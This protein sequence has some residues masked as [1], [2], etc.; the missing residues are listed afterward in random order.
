[1][2]SC[3]VLYRKRGKAKPQIGVVPVYGNSGRKIIDYKFLPHSGV[4]NLVDNTLQNMGI[5]GVLQTNAETHYDIT[6]R[7][8]TTIFFVQCKNIVSS[9]KEIVWVPLSTLRLKASIN[10]DMLTR[11]NT[12]VNNPTSYLG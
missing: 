4:A 10:S 5:K 2:S 9:T 7:V 8:R 6:N 3:I 1:M 11:L 12:F